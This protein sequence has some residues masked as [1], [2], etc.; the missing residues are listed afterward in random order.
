MLGKRVLVCT[1]AL[2]CLLAMA[3]TTP[4]DMEGKAME[5]FSLPAFF[6]N[7]MMFQQK[8]PMNLW[9]KAPSGRTVEAKLVREPTGQTVETAAA[10]A[11][12]AGDWALR[13]SPVHGGYDAYRIEVTCGAESKTIRDIVAG[14]LW[15]ATGQSNMEFML[16]NSVGGDDLIVNADDPY[17]RILL[18]PIEP[19]YGSKYPAEPAY[20]IAGA[21][22]E[23]GNNGGD[24]RYCSAVAYLAVKKMREKLDV[25]VGFIN[26]ARG[27]TSIQTWLPRQALEENERAVEYLKASGLYRTLEN[28][29]HGQMDIYQMTAAY[30]AK[31]G[32]LEGMN[33]GGVMWYQGETN[34]DGKPN[35]PG[36]YTEALSVLAEGYA[37]AFGFENGREMPLL[38]SHLAAHPYLNDPFNLAYWVEDVTAACE[39]Y[40]KMVQLPLYDAPLV[41]RDPPFSDYYPI[42]PSDKRVIG[43]RMGLAALHNVYGVGKADY[44][45]PTVKE[46]RFDQGKAYV[47]F[48][49]VGEGLASRG[50]LADLRGFALCGEER[51]FAPARA[52]LVSNDTVEVSNDALPDP[53]A[54]SY[55]F[56]SFNNSASLINSY[57]IPAVSFRSDSEPSAYLAPNDWLDCDSLTTWYSNATTAGEEPCWLPGKALG[58]EDV[59]LSLNM[60]DKAEGKG[61]LQMDYSVNSQ[62]DYLAGISPRLN[63]V[64]MPSNLDKYNIFSVLVKNPDDRAKELSLYVTYRGSLYQAETITGG[65]FCTIGPKTGFTRYVFDLNSLVNCTGG[66][67]PNKMVLNSAGLQLT[68]KDE[69]DGTLLF[70]GMELGFEAPETFALPFDYHY[71]YGDVDGDGDVNSLDALAVLKNNVGLEEFDA[72]QH[73]LADVDRNGQVD[74]V[75]ALNILQH[76]VGLLESFP[77]QE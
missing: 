48:G 52:R 13:F 23:Y 33:L 62:T 42:H 50:T 64:C 73:A 44:Y 56:A 39:R 53:V 2:S 35:E 32:P 1:A 70:D 21:R 76:S 10:K 24:I 54:V 68:V 15:L 47:T 27:A 69:K 12:A 46:V 25:P 17:I 34:R 9:G 65:D 72:K 19:V 22:W 18:E 29:S 74:A 26:A 7:G 20:D 66:E 5:E 63:D 4:M 14:E 55:A 57:G 16:A 49:H 6:S 51:V 36:Y 67:K 40:P 71:A 37:S 77:A 8:K 75:D 43:E 61:A 45:A 41:Y 28:F 60:R 31:I 30:N 59:N 3:F 38:V 58:S 11:G